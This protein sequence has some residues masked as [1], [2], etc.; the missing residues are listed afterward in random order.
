MSTDP[1]KFKPGT[2]V[3]VNSD[4]FGVFRGVVDRYSKY[5]DHRVIRVNSPGFN[6]HEYTANVNCLRVIK[7]WWRFW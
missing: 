7:P 3:I 2:R 4:G 1:S 6:F 5:G